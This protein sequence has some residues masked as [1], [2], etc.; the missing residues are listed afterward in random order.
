[1][2][3]KEYQERLCNLMNWLSV[4]IK[5]KCHLTA[6]ARMRD[7]AKLKQ[8]YDSTPWKDTYCQFL[9]EHTTHE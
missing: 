5:A 6:K 1:M 7:I 3:E 2:I 9:K 8:E 4:S